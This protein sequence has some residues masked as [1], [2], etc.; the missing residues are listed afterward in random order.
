MYKWVGTL[1]FFSLVSLKCSHMP[2]Q[3]MGDTSKYASDDDHK[4]PQ[5]LNSSA[6]TQCLTHS[7]SS[8]VSQGIIGEGTIKTIPFSKGWLGVYSSHRLPLDTRPNTGPKSGPM[9]P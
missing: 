1:S 2:S 9:I 5:G 3:G 7:R 4:P 6:P 8:M